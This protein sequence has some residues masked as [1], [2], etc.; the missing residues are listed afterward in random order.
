[1]PNPVITR[2]SKAELFYPIVAALIAEGQ[3][4]PG[5][6]P[7][8][9]LGAHRKC[10]AEGGRAAVGQALP[11]PGRPQDDLLEAAAI[12]VSIGGVGFRRCQLE[13]TGIVGRTEV[14]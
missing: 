4:L 10:N 6:V 9:V 5:S 3:R 11:A 14:D 13:G 7:L 1:M 2:I 8:L 12:H